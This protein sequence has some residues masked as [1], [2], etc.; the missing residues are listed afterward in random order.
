MIEID[1]CFNLL[2]FSSLPILVCI[3]IALVSSVMYMEK[4][5]ADVNHFRIFRVVSMNLFDYLLKILVS[6]TSLI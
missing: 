1:T 3:N 6:L 2:N 4:I 5:K